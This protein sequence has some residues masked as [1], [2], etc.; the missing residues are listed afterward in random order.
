MDSSKYIMDSH[1]I[2]FNNN[3]SYYL[4]IFKIII[5]SLNDLNSLTYDHS[6]LIDNFI[7]RLN[8]ANGHISD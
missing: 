8:K 1:F 3:Y 6:I 5:F 4:S 7:S 2:S